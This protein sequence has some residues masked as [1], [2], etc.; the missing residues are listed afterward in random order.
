M[1]RNKSRAAE[2][3]GPDPASIVRRVQE[4]VHD[5]RALLVAPTPENLDECRR[6]VDKAV[7]VLRQLQ[8]G[9]PSG[10]LKRD[11]P[12]RAP[13]SELRAEIARLHIL[14]DGAAAFHAGWVRLAASMVAGY[15]ADGTPG[16]PE[17]KRRVW[18]EV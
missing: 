6:R 15:T 2:V 5:A 10:D 1:P 18:M 7:N 8:S 13:L 9:L 17:P 4:M 3:Q 14:L 12:L 11:S 16:Q